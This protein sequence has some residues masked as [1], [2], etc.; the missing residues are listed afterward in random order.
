MNFTQLTY[1]VEHRIARIT[2]N[3][4]DKRNA[5]T[6]TLI[7]ELRDAFRDANENNDVRV[8]ILQAEGNAF[9]AGLDL[10]ELGKI[11]AM[12]TM[13]NIADTERLAALF[14]EIY[15]HKKFVISVVQGAAFAGGCGLA[16]AADVVVADNDNAKFCY[17]E[18]KIG[19]IPAVVA[20]LILRKSRNAGIR[21]MLLRAN[22]VSATDALR[23]GI[24]NY[25]V[26]S[27]ELHETASRIAEDVCNNTSPSS[28]EL[29]K[30][31]L[32]SAETMGLEDAVNFAISLNALSRTTD[33]L[34]RGIA[35]FLNKEKLTW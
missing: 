5:L 14:R 24:I 15:T 35:A 22:T 1:A 11:S 21:E 3:R 23:L 2:L 25:S 33:D 12:N 7:T 30:R 34:K 27:A 4:P 32:W 13:E 28:I 26:P 18:T 29:T 6:P 16:C 20:V 8:V 19:F 31:L 9:C 17:S 10:G